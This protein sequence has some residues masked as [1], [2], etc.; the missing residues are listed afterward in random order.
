MLRL[1]KPTFAIRVEVN[2]AACLTT[3]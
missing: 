2:N 1:L 3:T